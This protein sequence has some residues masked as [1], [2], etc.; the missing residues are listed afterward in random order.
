MWNIGR[1][2]RLPGLL[3]DELFAYP[4]EPVSY[5]HLDVYKRQD[6]GG[7]AKRAD[8]REIGFVLPVGT[9][10][11]LPAHLRR[12]GFAGDSFQ[13]V[14]YTHLDVYKRQTLPSYS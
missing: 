1:R 13:A 9:L 12:P 5:T 7:V 6:Q 4:L 14:S 10:E 2:E 8:N 11:S 3:D